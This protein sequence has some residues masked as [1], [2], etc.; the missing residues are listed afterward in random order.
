MLALLLNQKVPAMGVFRTLFYLP[1][2]MPAVAATL[3]W[4]WLLNPQFGI[5]NFFI[6]SLFGPDG[7]IPLGWSGRAGCRIRSGSFPRSP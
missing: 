5:L 1:A 6:R 7:L 3:L 2:I 4:L